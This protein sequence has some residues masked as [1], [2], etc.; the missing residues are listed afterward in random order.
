MGLA[1]IGRLLHGCLDRGIQPRTGCQAT[2]LIM[3]DGAVAGVRYR[4][5]GGVKEL[6]ASN[7]VLATGGFEWDAD[8]VRAFTRGP[9][10]HPVSIRT[11]T[12]DGLKM[13]M[14]VGAMLGNMREAWWMPVIEVPT[15]INP[16]LRWA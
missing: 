6:S 1:L 13:A 11:N 5:A 7:V 9:L 16:T 15:E 3:R 8:L 10:T 2:D 12:G 14:R 4:S